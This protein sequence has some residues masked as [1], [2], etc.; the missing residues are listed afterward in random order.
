MVESDVPLMTE[1]EMSSDSP[2]LRCAV[3][4]ATI[5]AGWAVTIIALVPVI[6]ERS[7][8][9]RAGAFICATIAGTLIAG[10]IF[11]LISLIIGNAP[12]A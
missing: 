2:I 8:D 9:A 7:A 11:Q 5:G 1:N 10:G 12:H 6:Q 3:G 4:A